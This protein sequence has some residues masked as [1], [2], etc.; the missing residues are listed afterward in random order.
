VHYHIW[1]HKF[2]DE[3]EEIFFCYPWLFNAPQQHHKPWPNCSLRSLCLLYVS[4]LLKQPPLSPLTL[5]VVAQQEPVFIRYVGFGIFKLYSLANQTNAVCSNYKKRAVQGTPV[6]YEYMKGLGVYYMYNECTGSEDAPTQ[7][8][9]NGWQSL[10]YSTV[11]NC[12]FSVIYDISAG[13]LSRIYV[14]FKSDNGF[15]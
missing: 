8:V 11:E 5:T 2:L 9:P 3:S 15:F 12:N 4:P 13:K 1:S 14:D 7:T 6:C 10:K